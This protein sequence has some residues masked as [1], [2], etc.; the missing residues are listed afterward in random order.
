L[1]ASAF[2]T[3]CFRETTTTTRVLSGVPAAIIAFICIW[4]LWLLRITDIKRI[5]SEVVETT[6]GVVRQIWAKRAADDDTLVGKSDA[7]SLDPIPKDTGDSM[8]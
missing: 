8:A 1:F 2:F 7:A 6:K 4:S 5:F 3:L